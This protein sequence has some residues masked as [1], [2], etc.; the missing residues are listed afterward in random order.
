M[1]YQL[2]Y[3][4]CLGSVEAIYYQE[5]NE[6]L[7]GISLW[8]RFSDIFVD[9]NMLKKQTIEINGEWVYLAS[10]VT[11]SYNSKT[12]EFSFIQNPDYKGMYEIVGY[13]KDVVSD[14]QS[15][16]CY[17]KSITKEEFELILDKY[18]NRFDSDNS[19][20]NLAYDTHI[21]E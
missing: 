5:K 1:K 16:I 9:A 11:V 15:V 4:K 20:Q 13:Q 10:L 12:H 18:G 21:I 8:L 14:K 19:L 3:D 6:Y 7:L 2:E 17:G